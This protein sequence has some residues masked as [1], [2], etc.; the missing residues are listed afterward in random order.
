[1]SKSG[2]RHFRCSGCRFATAL[3]VLLM[4]CL[5]NSWFRPVASAQA[6]SRD[7]PQFDV[8][9][10]FDGIIPE[11]DWFPVVCE[12]KNTGPSFNATFEFYDNGVGG[13][14]VR[15]LTVELP[16]GTLK[17]FSFPM[18][19]SFR[20][21]GQYA[22]VLRDEKGRAMAQTGSIRPQFTINWQSHLLV[23]IPASAAGMPS[24][25]DNPSRT[26]SARPVAATARLQPEM[27]P[28]NPLSL[29]GMDSFYLNSQ[30]AVDLSD[31]QVEALM[32]W[33]HD[34]GHLIV[35]IDAV[36]D[37]NGVPWLKSLVPGEL[38]SVVTAT[39]G[40]TFDQW[41]RDVPSD[42]SNG[43]PPGSNQIYQNL[44]SE[45]SFNAASIRLIAIRPVDA[46]TD[47]AIAGHPAILS[48]RV[49]R[50]RVSLLLFNP[51]LEP[52]RSWKLRPFFWARLNELPGIM[53]Q[54]QNTPN[55]GFAGV[56]GVIGA[57]VDSKQIRKL[58]VSAL[59]GLLVVYL[60]VIGP[61]D[62]WWLKRINR[63]M[64][65]WITFPCYVVMFSVLI[66]IIGYKLRAGESE[67]NEIQFVDVL[68]KGN[69]AEL[70]GATYGSLYSPVNASYLLGGRQRYAAFRSEYL[71]AMAGRSTEGRVHL[72][73]DQYDARVSVPV[74][75]SQS[76]ISQWL[77]DG[78]MP[79]TATI[80]AKDGLSNFEVA[81]TNRELPAGATVRIAV[82]RRV[83]DFKLPEK[84]KTATFELAAGGGMAISDFVNNATAWFYQAS[85]QRN[86][87]FGSDEAR[88]RLQ[89]PEATVAIT[90]A[91]FADA[92]RPN[93]FGGYTGRFLTPGH[94]DLSDLLQENFA[95]VMVWCDDYA[96]G[97]PMNQFK[98]RRSALS[99]LLRLAVPLN[100]KEN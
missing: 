85:I 81:L 22:A 80:R 11:S 63:Q 18:Y 32:S 67:W 62:Q 7:I 72:N 13:G 29:E 100:P 65:T 25:P 73:G 47:L 97:K 48:K 78:P 34:G 43:G 30:R 26:F 79:F 90:L 87:G 16:T 6:F 92:N 60:L 4:L 9:T 66:Y 19:T 89:P 38:G 94:L 42:S 14:L 39:I 69:A 10:G 44:R 35:G 91:G 52:L 84:G 58:P 28:D 59:L 61:F 82:G 53:L 17:R 24:F 96:P 41:F 40:T 75:T 5:V 21:G 95:L 54:N 27:F 77:D 33:L 1:M 76:Y 71:G 64:L 70:R 56:D 93:N 15:Q 23:A 98:P 45:D 2:V 3:L 99:S 51:E 57:M 36:V 37:V 49:G 8:F 31:R 74:W 50:G 83:Y 55:Q 86:Q 46:R 68:P 20:T 88:N 12:V